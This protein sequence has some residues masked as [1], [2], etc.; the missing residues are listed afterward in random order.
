[1]YFRFLNLTL[2]YFLT[3]CYIQNT[4]KDTYLCVGSKKLI[5]VILKIQILF[6]LK[7]LLVTF[8]IFLQSSAIYMEQTKIS[9]I[10]NHN[11]KKFSLSNFNSL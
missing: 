8:K 7:I 5:N 3:G 1:M 2:V 4:N 11:Y 10:Y 9:Q 6:T